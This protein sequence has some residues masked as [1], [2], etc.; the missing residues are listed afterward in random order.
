ME[1]NIPHSV[2]EI[3]D[4][5][6]PGCRK[7]KKVIL[8]E[9]I[10]YIGTWSFCHCDILEIN[11]PNSVLEIKDEA[12]GYCEKL[13]LGRDVFRECAGTPSYRKVYM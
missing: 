3:K 9:G 8:L 4:E 11:I 2:L 6:F 7:L 1:I 13:K 12:F 10:K 5:A